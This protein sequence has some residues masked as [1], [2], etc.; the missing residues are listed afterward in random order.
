MHH[1]C[2]GLEQTSTSTASKLSKHCLRHWAVPPMQDAGSLPAM[3][4]AVLLAY[5]DI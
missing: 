4:A 5:P 1:N 3:P 2:A